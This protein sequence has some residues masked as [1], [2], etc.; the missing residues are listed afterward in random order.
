VLWQPQGWPYINPLQDVHA[1]K[2]AV[3][4]G[5]KSRTAVVSEQGDDAEVIDAQQAADNERADALKL[6]YDSDGRRAAK[7]SALAPP[8]P[9]PDP[10]R[11]PAPAPAE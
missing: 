1:N 7:A 11:E 6:A 2:E 5:F 3:R 4:S 8:D 10:P 9:D